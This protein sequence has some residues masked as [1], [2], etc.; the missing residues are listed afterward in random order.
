MVARGQARGRPCRPRRHAGVVDPIGA[1]LPDA[2][3]RRRRTQ[4]S[5]NLVDVCP[6]QPGQ[7]ALHSVFG[8]IDTDA[9]Y[10]QNDQLLDNVIGLPACRPTSMQPARRSPSSPRSPGRWSNTHGE[11]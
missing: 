2:T 1:N 4:Y 11:A 7:A 10:A 6:V 9:V 8:Q 5:A 3:W